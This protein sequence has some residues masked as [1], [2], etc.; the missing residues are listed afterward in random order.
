MTRTHRLFQLMQS[1]RR[2]PP[3]VTAQ[4]LAYEMD[5]SLRTIYRDKAYPLCSG[6]TTC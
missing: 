5:V 3:P 4:S 6:K 1:L 2:L